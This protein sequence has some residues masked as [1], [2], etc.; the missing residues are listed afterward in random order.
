VVLNQIVL[1]I[2]AT[3][4]TGLLITS[5]LPRDGYRVRALA[6]NLAKARV[7]FDVSTDIVPG[8]ITRPETLPDALQDVDHVIFTAG[9]TKRPAGEELVRTTEYEGLRSVLA[10]A[11]TV[12]LPGRFLY[13]TSIGVSRRSLASI[14]LDLIKGNTLKWRRLAEDEIRRSDLDY[15]IIR[16]GFL[17]NAPGGRRPVR[18]SQSN[19]P[20]SAR[21]R[22]S[23]S[24]VAEVFVQALRNPST[25][26]T[27]FEVF[28]GKRG[29]RH[30]WRNLFA[31]LVRDSDARP[32]R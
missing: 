31:G 1:V 11:R 2:G 20:L 4:G 21:Y 23:R 28:W 13:M 3:R 14:I 32:S 16:A 7:R 25:R 12:G 24:D 27:T 10:A 22:I 18:I 8:D 6:R 17:T 30:D 5:L 19:H 15:T 29:E 9:V 26:R